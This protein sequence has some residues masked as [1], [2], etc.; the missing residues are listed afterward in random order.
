MPKCHGTDCSES[1]SHVCNEECF[2]PHSYTIVKNESKCL[3][4]YLPNGV[5]ALRP[6]HCV[7]TDVT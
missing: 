3:V 1:A 2:I 6:H 5:N 7:D 4:I